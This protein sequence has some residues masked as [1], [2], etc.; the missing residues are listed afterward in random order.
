MVNIIF[1]DGI[2]DPV[3]DSAKSLEEWCLSKWVHG[4]QVPRGM[5]IFLN[6]VSEENDITDKWFDDNSLLELDDITYVV[7]IFPS[8]GV[9]GAITK[10][11]G[12]ILNPIIKLLVPRAGATNPNM[13]NQRVS[14]SNNAL[15]GRT[16]E[17]RPGERIEDI[18][19]HV[20]AYPTLLMDYRIFHDRNEYE[21]QLLCLGRGEYQISD[22]RDGMTP[23][24]NI[25]GTDIEIY[26]PNNSPGNGSPYMR[27]GNNID[28]NK[29]P[30]IVAVSSNEADGSELRPPNYNDLSKVN[31]KIYS[32][33][34]IDTIGAQSIE[35][36]DRAVIGDDVELKEC[37]SWQKMVTTDPVTGAET[38]SYVRHSLNG[39]YKTLTLSDNM[40]I[41]DNSGNSAWGYLSI[42]GTNMV[43]EAWK[44]PT[45]G[46]YQFT[47]FS[48]G[49]KETYNPSIDAKTPFAIGP[50]LV[51]NADQIMVNLYAQNGVYKTDGDVYPFSVKCELSLSDPDNPSAPVITRQVT[52]TG[53][54]TDAVGATLKVNNPYK[55]RVNV[56]M[57]RLDNTDK[58]FEGSVVDSIKW[59]DLYAV[60]EIPPQQ[61]GNVTI[62]HAV[63]KSTVA[64]IKQKERKLNMDVIRLI[65]GQPKKNFAD[66]VKAMHVDPFV[67]RR[68]LESLD[69]DNLYHVE[70]Q[71]LNYYQNDKSVEVGYTFDNV[72]VT[73]E[74]ALSIIGNTVNCMPYQIGNNIYFWPELPQDVSAMQ[75]GHTFKIPGSDKRTRAFE[76]PKGQTGVQVKY[77]SHDTLTYQF[78]NI[79]DQTNLMKIDLQACQSRY[80]AL[81]K[82][83]REYNKLQYQRITHD[84]TVSAIGLQCSP[85]MRVDMVDNTRTLQN[86]GRIESV[87]G[88]VLTLSDPFNYVEGVD[89]TITITGRLGKLENIPI[90]K[91]DNDFEVILKSQ[92]TEEIYTGWMKDKTSYV[93][94]GSNNAN[95]LAMLV[96]S[97]EPSGKDDAYSVKLTC[98]NYDSRFYKDDKGA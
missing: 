51:E 18:Y 20:R 17:P 1:Y 54:Y 6:E 13:K 74:E 44:D 3:Y 76:S 16:N 40:I 72:S 22:I 97:V 26:K 63:T 60:T 36:G 69:M 92:N 2:S 64:A 98:V 86:D 55:D 49:I 59:R 67:G 15:A 61:Y 37:F 34:Q 71:M 70:Q 19:G 68:T 12:A 46:R 58:G 7:A 21:V 96:Q 77:F 29:F 82:A 52:V 62:I 94:K 42:T 39:L 89:Y 27:I 73:Y 65:D 43:R 31:M 80:L 4:E 79:G 45:T 14:S 93:I 11:I 41:V 90:E 91:G 75:F 38:I 50:Y 48:G 95:A 28:L 10:V 56:T 8:G 33:G 85:G 78:V 81:I 53:K 83:N 66:V 9:V 84:T 24:A 57:R 87:D 47:S 23:A 32:T 5:R 88:M 35:W 25:S 30:I